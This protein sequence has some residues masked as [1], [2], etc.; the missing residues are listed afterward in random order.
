M[1]HQRSMISPLATGAAALCAGLLTLSAFAADPPQGAVTAA[2]LAAQ[3]AATREDGSSFVRLRIEIRKPSARTKS[4]LQMQVKSRRTPNRADLVYQMLWPKERKG[5]AI[6]LTKTG[7]KPPTGSILTLPD[8]LQ[9][10][11][12]PKLK[13]SFFG[14]DLTLEDVAEDFYTWKNQAFVGT[15]VI[16]GVT[17]Q[18]LESLPGKGEWSGSPKVRSW[19]DLK[20]T[21]PLRVE[22][23]AGSGA[24]VRR[25]DTLKVVKE[26]GHHLPSTFLVRQPGKD[27][28]T[29]I[30]AVRGEREVSYTDSDF[31]PQGLKQ[32]A[33]PSQSSE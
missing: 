33:P 23:Y 26:R 16:D 14:T 15:E 4:V 1:S 19:I 27:S 28:E 8:T 30:E 20:R 24:L 3:L 22:K 31:T 5:E 21:V 9:P 10:L 29:E 32:L 12:A 11:D 7:T 6:L 13:G 18:I 17:C 25:I 2:S